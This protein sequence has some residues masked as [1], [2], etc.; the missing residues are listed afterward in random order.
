M[1]CHLKRILLVF[2]TMW[3]GYRAL[4]QIVE[5][6]NSTSSCEQVRVYSFTISDTL[7]FKYVA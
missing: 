6:T 4:Y 7:Q 2:V 5:H 1:Y 3:V